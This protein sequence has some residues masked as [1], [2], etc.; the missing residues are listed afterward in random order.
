MAPVDLLFNP[1]HFA[2]VADGD[3][4]ELSGCPEADPKAGFQSIP[5]LFQK[6]LLDLLV[7]LKG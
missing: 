6:T 3:I 4:F 5:T 2:K 7:F 1:S